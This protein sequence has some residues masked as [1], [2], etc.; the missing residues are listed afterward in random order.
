MCV[1]RRE[2]TDVI[3]ITGGKKIQPSL[4][5][6]YHTLM[7]QLNSTLFRK[8]VFLSINFIFHING[9]LNESTT[10]V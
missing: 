2:T 8:V 1:I 9:D 6:E 10:F 4:N 3:V 7:K 5:E